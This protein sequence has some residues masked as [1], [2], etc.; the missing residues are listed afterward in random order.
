MGMS[1]MRSSILTPKVDVMKQVIEIDVQEKMNDVVVNHYKEVINLKE[2]VI[3][4]ALIA[5]GWTPPDE[6]LS[7]GAKNT[8]LPQGSI[9]HEEG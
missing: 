9:A 6:K 2:K 7:N 5:L 4:E 8:E 3:R 1:F